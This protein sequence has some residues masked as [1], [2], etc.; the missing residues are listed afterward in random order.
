[1]RAGPSK[2]ETQRTGDVHA[3]QQQGRQQGNDEKPQGE[4]PLAGPQG[5]E[6]REDE[7]ED[8]RVHRG[9][10]GGRVITAPPFTPRDGLDR[11]K[12][13]PLTV[14]GLESR[15]SRSRWSGEESGDRRSWASS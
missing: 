12:S 3:E 2:V 14:Y 11:G 13:E 9:P 10:P 8:Q 7:Q 6:S 1:M 5:E 4:G 15:A